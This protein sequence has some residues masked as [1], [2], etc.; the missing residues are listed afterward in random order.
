MTSPVPPPPSSPRRSRRIS[1]EDAQNSPAS[2]AEK[3]PSSCPDTPE[4]PPIPPPALNGDQVDAMEVDQVPQQSQSQTN[5]NVATANVDASTPPPPTSSPIKSPTKKSGFAMSS[6]L[7]GGT[8]RNKSMSVDDETFENMLEK[9]ES[10]G[11]SNSTV[12]TTTTKVEVLE[13]PSMNPETPSNG[14][15]MQPSE[16]NGDSNAREKLG[17]PTKAKKSDDNGSSATPSKSPKSRKRQEELHIDDEV[18]NTSIAEA[19]LQT[20]KKYNV[21]VLER[22]EEILQLAHTLLLSV[23]GSP[24]SNDDVESAGKSSDKN[25]DKSDST[26]MDTSDETKTPSDRPSTEAV[27]ASKSESGK[28]QKTTESEGTETADVKTEVNKTVESQNGTKSQEASSQK[29]DTLSSDLLTQLK[30]G[31]LSI[32]DQL[33]QLQFASVQAEV[34]LIKSVKRAKEEATIILKEEKPRRGYKKK[35][36]KVRKQSSLQK[37]KKP[38]KKKKKTS[39]LQLSN[40]GGVIASRLYTS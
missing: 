19:A 33:Q 20:G 11:L 39:S 8:P 6:I 1:N 36:A 16:V 18:A 15:D 14:A 27:D 24:Q 35:S 34:D 9:K 26:P 2:K 12:S 10:E 38:K 13:P 29:S 32:Q 40:Q 25:I 30:N 17:E 3:D 5:E 4:P 37:L 22:T 7:S 31:L 23:T 21:V 28:T